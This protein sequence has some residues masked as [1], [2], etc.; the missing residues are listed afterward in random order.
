LTLGDNVNSISGATV[1]IVNPLNGA[2]EILSANVTGTN[3]TASYDSNTGILTL[4]GNDTLVNYRNVLRSVTYDN[5]SINPTLGNR[6]LEF[7]VTDA[8]AFNNTSAVARTTIAYS[9]DQIIDGTAAAETINGN[10]GNDTLNGLGGNDTLN[11]GNDNDRL[12]GG[13]QNDRLVGGAG[14]D[15][16][17]GGNNNDVLLGSSGNDSLDGGLGN[18][19]LTGGTENDRFV[20][21]ATNGTDTVAD[22]TNGQD[23]FFLAGGLTFGSLTI[24]QSAADTLIT[25][26]STSEVLAIVTGVSSSLITAA[27]FT[28]V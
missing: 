9:P 8:G 13:N 24:S 2:S 27:D 26:T 14:L 16:L 28:T 3:V 20:L 21:R 6:T 19:T 15:T 5:T 11:G 4:S 12:N 10:A 17:L 7:V 23:L 1:R 22:F 18:D 25:N